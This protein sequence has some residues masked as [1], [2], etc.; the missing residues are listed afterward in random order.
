VGSEV[1]V[2]LCTKPIIFI[3]CSLLCFRKF[4]G[5]GRIPMLKLAGSPLSPSRP[6]PVDANPEENPVDDDRVKT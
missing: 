5:D 4:L 1:P 6:V 3:D 2:H